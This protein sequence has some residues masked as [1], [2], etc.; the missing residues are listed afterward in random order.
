MSDYRSSQ[1]PQYG[2]RPQGQ[3]PFPPQEPQ[4]SGIRRG[5]TPPSG[6]AIPRQPMAPYAVYPGSNTPVPSAPS[7]PRA[8][9]PNGNVSRRPSGIAAYRK[10]I[11][12]A[13]AVLAVVLIAVFAFGS[14]PDQA[15]VR[16]AVR[17]TVELHYSIFCP[18]VYVDGLSLGGL[19]AEE[20]WTA[21]RNR[22]LQKLNAWHVNLTYNGFTNTITADD[23]GIEPDFSSALD[24]AWEVGHNFNGK[25]S[26]RELYDEIARVAEEPRY[27]TSKYTAGDLSRIVDI[28]YTIKKSLDRPPQDAQMTGFYPDRENPF[29]YVDEIPGLN[30]DAQALIDRITDLASRLE[31]GALEIEPEQ[32]PPQQTRNSLSLLYTKRGEAVTQISTSSDANRNDNIR[33]AFSRFNGYRLDPGAVF[34]F[35]GIVGERSEKNKFKPAEE[36]DQGE[37]V[38]GIGGGVCQ[39]STTVYQAA[40]KAGLEVTDRSYHSDKV[41]YTDYGLDATVSWGSNRKVDLK[42]VNNTDS[43]VYIAA[44]VEPGKNGKNSLQTH[45]I[46]YGMDLGGTSYDIKSEKTGELVASGGPKYIKDTDGK[47]AT[48]TDEQVS[49]SDP[50]MGYEYMTYREEYHNGRLVER[51]DLDRCTYPAQPEKIYVGVKKR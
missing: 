43:P 47:Y 16:D 21:V 29:D 7:G 46:I 32:V 24:A 6:T 8:R 37:H 5:Y 36:Y 1:Y 11:F 45:V 27:F 34:S 22:S 48:Y 18:G 23:L 13:A 19:T 35:N 41:N 12:I 14:R 42:F 3:V 26:D 51:K 10:I 49:V 9:V 30:L 44:R 38:M 2:V 25:R 33:L 4:Q 40:V 20:G 28:V 17:A 39:A 50:K 31:S 15:P